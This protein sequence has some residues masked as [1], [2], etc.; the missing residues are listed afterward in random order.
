[1]DVAME[2]RRLE[3]LFARFRDRGDVAALGEV[4]DATAPDLARIARRITRDRSEAE[5]VLQSTFLAAIEGAKSFESGRRVM[6]WLVGVLVRQAGLARR[7]RG[8]LIP[9]EIQ[10][11]AAQRSEAE[12]SDVAAARETAEAIALALEK[13]SPADREVLVPLLVDGRRAV[14]IARE[15]DRRPDTV[16]MRIHRGLARLRRLLAPGIGLGLVGTLL[17]RR[18]LGSV[19]AHVIRAARLSVGAQPA[20]QVAV[21]SAVVVGGVLVMKKLVIGACLCALVLSLGWIAWTRGDSAARLTDASPGAPRLSTSLVPAF[22]DQ[23]ENVE[24]THRATDSLRSTVASEGEPS[25]RIEIIDPDGRPAVGA[26]VMIAIGT[27]PL[28]DTKTDAQ[29]RIALAASREPAELYIGRANAFPHRADLVLDGEEHRVDLPRG[30]EVSGRVR[31]GGSV[32]EHSLQVGLCSNQLPFENKEMKAAFARLLACQY[33]DYL[34]LEQS[35]AVDGT[36]CWTGLPESWSGS[37]RIPWTYT[38]PDAAKRSFGNQFLKCERPGSGLV[39][40]LEKMPCLKGRIVEARTRAPLAR[41]HVQAFVAWSDGGNTTEVGATADEAGRFETPLLEENF[42]TFELSSLTD[43][44][45]L[46]TGSLK[47]QRSEIGP[48]L[49]LGDIPLERPE[50]HDVQFVVRDPKGSAIPGAVANAGKLVSQAT[51]ER[52]LGALDSVPVETSSMRIYAR[53][54]W[55]GT[56]EIPRDAHDPLSVVLDPGNELAIELIGL[57]AYRQED[58]ELQLAS[59]KPTF[60]NSNSWLPDWTIREVTAGTCWSASPSSKVRKIGFT[61]CAVDDAGRFVAQDLQ[62]DV[63]MTLRVFG[64]FQEQLDELVIEPL[65]RS[66]RRCVKIQLKEPAR[67]LQGR[68]RSAEGDPIARTKITLTRADKESWS[69]ECGADGSFH[70]PLPADGIFSL[71]A[72]KRG[73]CD[74]EIPTLESALSVSP[75]ELRLEPGHDVTVDVFDGKGA[76]VPDPH[77]DARAPSMSKVWLSSEDREGRLHIQDLPGTICTL[78]L[79]VGGIERDLAHDARVPEA[80]FELPVLGNVEVSWD[81][82]A[83]VVPSDTFDQIALRPCDSPR[84]LLE[85]MIQT[86]VRG[87]HT[88][89]SMVPGE[90]TVAIERYVPGHPDMPEVYEVLTTPVHVT[91]VADQTTHVT[92]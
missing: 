35:T 61:T 78:T 38:L 14:D 40:E 88:F 48:G 58:I 19:R 7:R 53:G 89:S 9:R 8:A 68:V 71:A 60:A 5:D 76:R 24:T 64:P 65:G 56:V 31:V 23:G 57:S 39:L 20:T 4:F 46:G 83:V 11:E 67:I 25:T 12:P 73:W 72:S 81:R 62:T 55:A 45:G 86:D 26:L 1:M 80:R 3:E 16:S 70:F 30:L 85:H 84:V 32:P 69:R 29:G 44:N 50:S 37:I 17:A 15:L 54:F 77:L 79:R 63:P 10:R 2:D 74:R 51:D 13:L 47:L 59:E 75:L 92:L 52:G 28:T 18:G 87:S 91:V 66:E 21:S 6:P 49:D 22:G 42:L 33:P 34:V 82:T 27:S 41:A 90:Y 36:F 43:A